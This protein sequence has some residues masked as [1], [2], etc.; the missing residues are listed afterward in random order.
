MDAK[1]AVGDKVD[2]LR[3]EKQQSSSPTPVSH[4]ICQLIGNA[5]GR[6]L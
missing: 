6:S 3:R 1:F 4:G 2:Q 5:V